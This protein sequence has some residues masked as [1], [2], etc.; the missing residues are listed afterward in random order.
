MDGWIESLRK[1][2]RD[3]PKARLIAA[4]LIILALL[5]IIVGPR[6]GRDYQRQI[7]NELLLAEAICESSRT[8]VLANLRRLKLGQGDL[9]HITVNGKPVEL[10][11][12]AYPKVMFMDSGIEK[13]GKGRTAQDIYCV[14]GDPRTAGDRKY[15]KYD[16]RIW[17]EKVRFRR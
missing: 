3:Q 7:Y 13:I 16:E 6:F 12:V 5:Y 8:W 9:R 1:W 4:A 2:Y 11:Y 15:Y 17:V 10:E 14:Y